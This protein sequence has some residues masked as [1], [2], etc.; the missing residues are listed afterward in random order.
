[1]LALK[2]DKGFQF[3]FLEIGTINN[4]MAQL[5]PDLSQ[6]PCYRTIMLIII[7]IC[8]DM[9]EYRIVNST[10]YVRSIRLY[11]TT[12]FLLTQCICNSLVTLYTWCTKK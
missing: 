5:Y 11:T 4:T 8:I 9:Y 7:R 12:E 1:M 6:K 10:T 3:I 2:T